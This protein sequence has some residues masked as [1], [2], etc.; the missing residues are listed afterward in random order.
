MFKLPVRK[1]PTVRTVE[2]GL[3]GDF[4][5][6]EIAS[7]ARLGTLVHFESGETLMTEGAD[8][9]YVYVIASGFAAV[10]RGGEHVAVLRAG[11]LVGERSVVTG[12]PRNA[13][14]HA[15]MLVTALR[16]DRT[17]FAWLRLEWDTLNR[18]TNELAQIRS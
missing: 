13:T 6:G 12:D 3:R 2:P 10:S 18:V 11:D 5:E 4:T 17:R 14:V 8:G 16:F 1:S 15:F 7:M 9:S